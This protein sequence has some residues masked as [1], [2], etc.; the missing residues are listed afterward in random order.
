MEDADLTE[1][2]SVVCLAAFGK[3]NTTFSFFLR[4]EN[5]DFMF[6]CF[7]CLKEDI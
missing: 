5:M 3:K 4:V 2:G 7:Y 6:L 1:R